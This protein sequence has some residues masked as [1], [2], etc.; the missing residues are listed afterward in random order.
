[1]WGS[2][3]KVAF[4]A[5][6]VFATNCLFS[7][8]MPRIFDY[9]ITAPSSLFVYDFNRDGLNDVIGTSWSPGQIFLW[10]NE[11]GNPPTWSREEVASNI[12]GASFAMAGFI[13]GDS[14]PDIVSSGWYANE[15]AFFKNDTLSGWTKQILSDSFI[16]AHEVWTY[17]IDA[18]GDMDVI[19]ASAGSSGIRWWRNDGGNPILWTE[20]AF[21]GNIAGGRSVNCVD[22]DG[23][24]DLDVIACGATS[25]TILWWENN[26]QIPVGW[27]EHS[28]E[29]NFRGAHMV[30][31]ADMDQ[32]GK[33]DILGAAFTDNQIAVWYNTMG[34]S[35]EWEKEIIQGGFSAALG[36]K[37][38]KLDTDSYPDIIGTAYSSS[39]L[40]VWIKTIILPDTYWEAYYLDYN[41]SGAWALATGD[42]NQDGMP[43][44]IAGANTGNMI[45]W[46]ENGFGTAV[47]EPVDEIKTGIYGSNPIRA[48]WMPETMNVVIE[49][50][51]E[52]NLSYHVEIYDVS[53]ALIKEFPDMMFQRGIHSICWD[54]KSPDFTTVSSGIYFVS[55]KTNQGIFNTSV[56]VIK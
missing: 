20:L 45:K 54:C 55:L 27:T 5:V 9:S 40:V 22:L 24:S 31:T 33:P 18:D 4:V 42:L 28:V 2:F 47:E 11:G 32:D 16:Q 6:L 17:D 29:N 36:V 34:D 53:G 43:D 19:G 13:D 37:P 3:K 44:I 50:Y 1:M 46:Y 51:C 23:D 25:N 39:D 30:R 15:I 49:L 8:F 10:T 14:L 7:Q 41:L 12:S 52:N 21:G 48:S 26:G 56:T 38:E 35:I